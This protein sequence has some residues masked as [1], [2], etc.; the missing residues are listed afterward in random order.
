VDERQSPQLA[1][2]GLGK[3]TGPFVGWPKRLGLLSPLFLL[4]LA[5]CF[6]T[7]KLQLMKLSNFTFGVLVGLVLALSPRPAVLASAPLSVRWAVAPPTALPT[8]NPRV[9]TGRPVHRPSWA[10][11]AVAKWLTKKAARRLAKA[12]TRRT[13]WTTLASFACGLFALCFFYFFF[14]SVVA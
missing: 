1:R 8:E 4:I 6:F 13:H 7:P 11:R 10:E 5:R 14:F 12:D 2:F 3:A 9:A